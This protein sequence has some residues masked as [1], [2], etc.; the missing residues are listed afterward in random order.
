MHLDNPSH[1]DTS[2]T[3]WIELGGKIVKFRH[4]YV[5]FALLLTETQDAKLER[6]ELSVWHP[7]LGDAHKGR[8]TH[9][10]VHSSSEGALWW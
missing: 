6:P 5:I 4:D 9:P 2:F 8:S 10:N 1:I 3:V 7:Y